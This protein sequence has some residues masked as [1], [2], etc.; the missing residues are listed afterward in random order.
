MGDLSARAMAAYDAIRDETGALRTPYAAFQARTGIDVTQPPEPV[1]SDLLRCSL[2]GS[3]EIY[4]V[5]FILDEDEYHST[6]VPAMLQRAFLLQALFED[7]AIGS[8]K[9]LNA[10]ILAADE[11][12]RILLSEGASIASL[13]RLWHGQ[14]REQIRFVYGPDLVQSRAGN[15]VVLEDNVGC[16][17]GVAH[18]SATLE[19]YLQA[20]GLPAEIPCGA[21]GDLEQ[22]VNAFLDRTGVNRNQG[23]LYGFA[24]WNSPGGG[25]SPDFE[26]RRK[27]DC[28]R[29]FG[30]AVTD[31]DEL[32]DR[33]CRETTEISAIVNLSSTMSPAYQSLATYFFKMSNVPVFGAPCV[34]LVASK[35]FLPFDEDL[36]RL[37]LDEPLMIR[38]ASSR[39][40][41]KPP[42]R[43]PSEGVLKRSNGCQGTEVY[44][45]EDLRDDAARGVLLAALRGW[46]PCASIWQE[47]VER[48]V[49]P[50]SEPGR[51]SAILELRPIVYVYGWR[52]AL[53]AQV[54]A[55]RA[56]TTGGRLGNVSRGACL[57]PVL[58]QVLPGKK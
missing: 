48:S 54:L 37:Y 49:L 40:I 46:G 26:T 13:R 1:V 45:L 2:V 10:G 51:R 6:I 38:S 43:L 17:G 18:A 56:I 9:L 11:L 23:G 34:G 35:S 8:T 42:D 36:A 29:S 20:T 16:V 12:D 39:L 5:P 52:A 41:R 31:P 25:C 33:L 3:Q 55:G 30:I 19:A 53:V 28:L 15:W 57:L 44:F 22:A 21:R 58:R 27:A 24:G 50:G 14:P 47:L 7:V 32:L 4:P